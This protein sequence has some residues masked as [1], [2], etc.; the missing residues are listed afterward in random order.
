MR[1]VPGL[2]AIRSFSLLLLVGLVALPTIA[3]AQQLL[4]HQSLGTLGGFSDANAVSPEGDVA[5]TSETGNGVHGFYW[6]EATGMRDVGT[7]AGTPGA[8]SLAW[9]VRKGIVVGESDAPG[10]ARH[11]FAWNRITGVLQDLGTLGGASSAAY[12]INGSGVI[13]GQSQKA[14]G[15]TVAARWTPNAS[16]GYS[17]SEMTS[18]PEPYSTAYGIDDAGNMVGGWTEPGGGQTVKAFMASAPDAQ[19]AMSISS[20]PSTFGVWSHAWGI[21]AQGLVFGQWQDSSGASLGFTWIP[22]SA[23][24][25]VGALASPTP[26]SNVDNI[27]SNGLLAGNSMGATGLTQPIRYSRAEGLTEL[28]TLPGG[29]GTGYATGINAWGLTVGG[30]M[31]GGN[32]RPVAWIPEVGITEL[33]T[34]LSTGSFGWVR[35]INDSGFAVGYGTSA[36]GQHTAFLWRFS[37]PPVPGPQGPAGP[38]GP[39]GPQGPQGVQG[40][41]GLQGEKG[42]T[43]EK[44]DKGDAGPVGPAGPEGPAGP[45]GPQGPAGLNGADGAPGVAGP[46]G[47]PGPIGPQGPAGVDGAQGPK[48][49]TGATGPVGP[50]GPAGTNGLDGA[51]GAV[52]PQGPTGADGTNGVDG[53]PGAVGPQG[54]AG[55]DGA[56][57]PKGDTGASGPAGPQG[58]AGL[59]GVDGVAGAPGAPGPI[60]PAGPAGPQGLQGV[61][62]ALGPM[63]PMGPQG[64]AGPQGVAG[65]TNWPIGSVLYLVD[66][67]APPPG[68]VLLGSFKQEFKTPDGRNNGRGRDDDRDNGASR[69]VIIKFYVRR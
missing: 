17:I 45:V 38:A 18:L 37:A 14:N 59:N 49:D 11:A 30:S 1:H 54:P 21:N 33:P 36:S 46:Q 56:Q 3:Q 27:S 35:A 64:P 23:P 16:G 41:Q 24:L 7:L 69:S 57:G 44:G 10:G 66:G 68:F 32:W 25:S 51:P 22:G 13:A 5:G 29:D 42:D 58:P 2:S 60:G 15:S 47:E 50:Q 53:A 62:G 20:P 26:N 43:G 12:A 67:A 65:N 34:G 28:P 19:G 61:A 39:A 8:T 9:G 40:P 52:G 48:G 55:A 4:S 63:G 31:L 6:S